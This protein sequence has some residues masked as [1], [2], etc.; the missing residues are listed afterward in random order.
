MPDASPRCGSVRMGTFCLVFEQL[1]ERGID[2]DFLRPRA[3]LD[4]ERITQTAA[5][6][7]TF[8]FLIRDFPGMGLQGDFASLRDGD[9]RLTG[10]LL[11]GIGQRWRRKHQQD[12][13]GAQAIRGG[14]I[15]CFSNSP[16]LACGCA[17][18]RRRA[19]S[20]ELTMAPETEDRMS[21]CKKEKIYPAMPGTW[22]VR[23]R[24]QTRRDD[25]RRSGQD[26]CAWQ[27][28]A[29]SPARGRDPYPESRRR[30][31]R[32]AGLGKRRLH[33]QMACTARRYRS[34]LRTTRAIP[35]SN[36]ATSRRPPCVH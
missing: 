35:R 4:V 8:E 7:F 21:L 32:R 17:T 16:P 18:R 34:D 13:C 31:A 1:A 11:T 24:R 3:V 26:R 28:A 14:L 6:G 5:A 2:A 10:E 22:R 19:G 15:I 12:T 36:H 25:F 9:L 33:R 23:E 20:D 27:F 30:F 29:R